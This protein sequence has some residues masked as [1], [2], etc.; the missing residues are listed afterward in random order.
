MAPHPPMRGLVCGVGRVITGESILNFVLRS[1]GQ[2]QARQVIYDGLTARGGDDAD[3]WVEA[4]VLDKID[5]MAGCPLDAAETILQGLA[6]TPGFAELVDW[7]GREGMPVLLCGPV[8]RLFTELLLRP[9][10]W[11]HLRV[12]GSELRIVDGRIAG[13][14]T[15]C[16]PS[17]KRARVTEWLACHG[18]EAAQ[19]WAIGDAS[20]DRDMLQMMPWPNRISFGVGAAEALER[21][22]TSAAFAGGMEALLRH[23]Q[24]RA[25]VAA[26]DNFS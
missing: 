15:V 6:P 1:L 7:C 13:V 9:Y 25:H 24:A 23:V 19:C 14:E 4:G 22:A 18:L 21:Q 12:A 5:A 17:R 2:P 11:P 26:H 20:G 3:A 16:T 8:P 10:R